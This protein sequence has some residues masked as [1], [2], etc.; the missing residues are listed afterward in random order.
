MNWWERHSLAVVAKEVPHGVICL[1]SALRFHE[2]STQQPSEVWIDIPTRGWCPD[3]DRGTTSGSLF[4]DDVQGGSAHPSDRGVPVRIF[5]PA[6]TVADCFKY[7]N[8]IGLDVALQA[9]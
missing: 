9:L 5:E 1:L 4:G 8:K 3:F 6:K 2:L 7:R